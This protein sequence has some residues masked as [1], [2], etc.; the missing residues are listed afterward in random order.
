MPILAASASYPGLGQFLNGRE[1]KA[2]VIG[3]AEALL[4]A[5]LVVEDRRTRNAYRHYQE[6]REAAWFDEYSRHYDRRQTLLWWV[7]GAALYAMTDAYVDAHLEG[8]GESLSP[9]LEGPLSIDPETT[10][11]RVAVGLSV[12]F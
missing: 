9:E 12:R 4:V 3:A 7:I 11:E 10:S 2:A 6:T 5:G 8:F 1:A